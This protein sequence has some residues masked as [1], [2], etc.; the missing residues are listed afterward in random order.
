MKKLILE[1]QNE[2]KVTLSDELRSGRGIPYKKLYVDGKSTEFNI[3]LKSINPSDKNK[4]IATKFGGIYDG[5]ERRYWWY[6]EEGNPKFNYQ[7][8]I[9][10]K[11]KPFIE[12]VN[13]FYKYTLSIDELIS[14]LTDFVPKNPNEATP[15]QANE[16]KDRVLVFKERILN[17]SSSEELHN[18]MKLMSTVQN[19]K[20]ESRF[21][22]DNRLAIKLQRPNATIVCNPKHWKDWYNRT[23]NE[24]AEPIFVNTANSGVS[25]D[26]NIT[27]DFLSSVGAASKNDLTGSQKSQLHTKQTQA[28]Y[29]EA[30]IYAWLKFYDVADTTQIPGTF[31]EITKNA[32]DAAAAAAELHGKKIDSDVETTSEITKIKPV[33]D[34]LLAYA[35]AQNINVNSKDRSETPNINASKNVDASTTKLLASALLSQILH[36]R[37]LKGRGGVASKLSADVTSPQAQRQQ[38]EVASWQFME[39]FD[40]K[41]NLA[42]VD[43]N[44][45]FGTIQTNKDPDAEKLRITKNINEVLKAIEG[46]VNHL[47]DF[48]NVEIKDNANLTEIEGRLPQGKHVTASGIAKDLGIPSD[49]LSDVD[50]QNLK[51]SLV[52][53]LNIKML[54]ESLKRKILTK[55]F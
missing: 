3:Y 15:Q 52:R 40:I 8:I 2:W 24:G 48:V 53:K 19:G 37:Y 35:K 47:I 1:N 9:N 25:N 27:K 39:A 18:T 41:Y 14:S 43:F 4:G 22:P 6:V 42:D 11:I 29:G 38:A 7:T 28:K 50:I 45:I 20:S 5:K 54:S 17:M 36:G 44:S 21:S 16:I 13:E 10:D 12:A 23:V 26:S 31:D 51:E 32:E 46:A 33:Y 30:K 49:M 55:K 34:G